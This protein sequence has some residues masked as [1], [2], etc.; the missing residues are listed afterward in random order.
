MFIII[1]YYYNNAYYIKVYIDV[2]IIVHLL[3]KTY[4]SENIKREI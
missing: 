3:L 2:F 1:C 4:L